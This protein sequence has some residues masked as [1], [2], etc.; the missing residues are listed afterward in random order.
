MAGSIDL[1]QSMGTL[2]PENVKLKWNLI[3]DI[4]ELDQ[5]DVNVTLNGNEINLPK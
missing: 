3:W 4:I 1:F 5:K 2:T